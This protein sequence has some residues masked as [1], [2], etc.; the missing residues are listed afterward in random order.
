MAF[1]PALISTF[2][3][4]VIL[5]PIEKSAQGVELGPIKG[6]TV[7]IV[8]RFTMRNPRV[9]TSRRIARRTS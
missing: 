2:F 5:A 8:T 6:Y 7:R 1:H 4:I 9:R 3:E